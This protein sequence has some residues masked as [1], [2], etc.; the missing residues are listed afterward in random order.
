MTSLPDLVIEQHRHGPLWNLSYLVGCV[1]SGE[2]VLVDPGADAEPLLARAE[3]L[4]LRVTAVVATHFHRDHTAG[5]ERLT[6]S[7]GATVYLH[8]A[9]ASGLRAYYQ[10]PLR[11]VAHDT[12]ICLGAHTLRLWHAP[13]HTPGS[14]WLLAGDAVFT[15]DA[16]MVGCVGRTGH[17]PDAAA[18]MWQTMRERFAALPDDVRIFPGHDYG[19]TRWSTVAIERARNRCLHAAT[20]AEFLDCID[21]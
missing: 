5:I 4:S 17:E 9:D 18:M 6:R 3:A 11:T 8:H 2:A 15:G 1:A 21:P 19:P 13:G 16:L 7:T 14:Q 12:T 20:L 10:G